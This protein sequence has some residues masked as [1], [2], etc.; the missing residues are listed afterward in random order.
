MVVFTASK[1]QLISHDRM[2]DGGD[3]LARFHKSGWKH[4]LRGVGTSHPVFVYQKLPRIE[5]V[6]DNNLLEMELLLDE[7]LLWTGI[8]YLSFWQYA[9]SRVVPLLIVIAFIAFL[10]AINLNL[11]FLVITNLFLPLVVLFVT[12][13]AFWEWRRIRSGKVISYAITTKRVLLRDKKRQQNIFIERI[14]DLQLTLGGSE[15]G[16]LLLYV[17]TDS[18]YVLSCIKDA[19]YV[20]QLLRS[21]GAELRSHLKSHD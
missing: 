5:T 4:L 19:E 21:L 6:M 1:R 14:S 18:F 9:R 13:A 16:T 7:K 15:T 3:V 20:F 8:P 17:D 10:G 11:P 12:S 2:L